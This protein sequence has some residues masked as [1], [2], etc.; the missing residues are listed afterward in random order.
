MSQSG[1]R[2]AHIGIAVTSLD[3][4]AAF[5]REVLGLTTSQPETADGAR[6]VSV[7]LGDV[8]IEFLTPA[9]PDGPIAR[10]LQRRGPGIHHLCY[11]VP[12]LDRALERARA[13][14][15]RLIDEEPRTGVGGHRIAFIHPKSTGGHLI[16]L[17]D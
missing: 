15:Y 6:I 1:A 9:T 3:E 11:R 14:G 13:N 2:L 5:Y 8:D 4:A 12:N 16:E 10:F 17:T 7:R